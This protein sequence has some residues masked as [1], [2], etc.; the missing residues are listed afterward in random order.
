MAGIDL[1]VV[2]HLPGQ[3][4]RPPESW[5][6]AFKIGLSP[7]LSSDALARHPAFAGGRAAFDAGYYWEAHELW[8]AVWTCLPPASADRHLLRGLIQLA[9][10]GLKRRMGRPEAVRRILVLAETA[11]DEAFL[12]G[13]HRLMGVSR[14]D[15]DA[16]SGDAMAGLPPG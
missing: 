9:N 8:E 14:E 11:L 1:P 13:R 12:T 16:M 3:T 15:A 10:A 6:D 4:P 5:S 2:P 7:G